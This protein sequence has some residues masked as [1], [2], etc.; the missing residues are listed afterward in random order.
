MKKTGTFGAA[1]S[2]VTCND[3][4]NV[5]GVNAQCGGSTPM[6]YHEQCVECSAQQGGCGAG[7]QCNSN[8]CECG[9]GLVKKTGTFGLST[10]CVACN[11]NLG[12]RLRE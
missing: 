3:A 12:A 11:D 4:D 6:C 9:S 10:T 1:T 7:S 2:C 8:T 5:N